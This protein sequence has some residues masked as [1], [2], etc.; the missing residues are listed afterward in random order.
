MQFSSKIEI[1]VML[2]L[3]VTLITFIAITQNQGAK[4]M[5]APLKYAMVDMSKSNKVDISCYCGANDVRFVP[6]IANKSGIFFQDDISS[7]N[8]ISYP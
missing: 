5:A 2:L 4:C 1:G 6:M 8:I 7:P 3:I